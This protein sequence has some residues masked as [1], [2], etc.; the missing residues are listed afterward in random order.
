MLGNKEIMAENI[1]FYMEQKGVNSAEVCRALGFKTNTF[2]D[3]T[4]GKAYPRIDKI[5]KMANYF[6]ISKANLVENR[7]DM[8]DTLTLSQEEHDMIINYRQ[9]DQSQQ[10]MVKRLLMYGD[11]LNDDRKKSK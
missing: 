1:K 3:W 10:R 6:G 4:T 8:I 9:L 2:S 11:L 7:L 5:E